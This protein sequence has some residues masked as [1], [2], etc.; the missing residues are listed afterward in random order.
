MQC[1]SC[2]FSAKLAAGEIPPNTRYEDTPCA[3]CDG[4][5]VERFVLEFDEKIHDK[6][7]PI[8]TVEQDIYGEEEEPCLP[9]GILAK[10]LK[11]LLHVKRADQEI[12][13]LRYEGM[14]YAKIGRRIGVSGNVASKRVLAALRACPALKLLLPRYVGRE[15]G[16]K[17]KKKL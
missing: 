15:K 17:S 10:V 4:M 11:L 13:I 1:S 7:E 12:V 16:W 8:N 9:V 6:Q 5:A 2:E 14:S 3:H